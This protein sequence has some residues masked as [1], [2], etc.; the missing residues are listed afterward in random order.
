MSRHAR[1]AAGARPA[2]E[3]A[4]LHARGDCYLGLSRGEGWG[5]GL[6]DACARGKPVIATAHG[7]PRDYLG[8]EAWQ[9]PWRAVPVEP[10]NHERLVYTREM[11]WAEPDWRHATRCIRE[12]L[13]DPAAARQRARGAAERVG[14]SFGWRPATEQ[15]WAV[16]ERARSVAVA[17]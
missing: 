15:V 10:R 8:D 4:W 6:F 13:A 12:V 14:R 3:L 9:V 7:G 2:S 5:L 11:H 17:A 1:N 16:F